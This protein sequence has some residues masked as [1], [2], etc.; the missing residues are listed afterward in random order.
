[1]SLFK[2]LAIVGA[3]SA[4]LF[5][6]L[7]ASGTASADGGHG[8]GPGWWMDDYCWN[9]NTQTFDTT[10]CQL[11]WGGLAR[12]WLVYNPA[13]GTTY[14]Y[15]PYFTY[16]GYYYY[17]YGYYPYGYPYGGYPYYGYA[18]YPVS[19]TYPVYMVGPYNVAAIAYQNCSTVPVLYITGYW[20]NG[21]WYPY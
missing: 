6:G 18:G 1:M 4:V 8:H 5:L 10:K 21:A 15:N 7:G 13:F 20:C 14:A 12:G 3:L 9:Q 2:K 16:A 11:I 19:V 17:G